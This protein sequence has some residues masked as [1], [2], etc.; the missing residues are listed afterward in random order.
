MCSLCVCSN[1][2]SLACARPIPRTSRLATLLASYAER[3]ARAYPLTKAKIKH[4]EAG[5]SSSEGPCPDSKRDSSSRAVVPPTPS[6]AAYPGCCCPGSVREERMQATKGIGARAER[7]AL[8]HL[9]RFRADGMLLRCLLRVPSIMKLWVFQCPCA[10]GLVA[11][12]GVCIA[13]IARG[14]RAERGIGREGERGG[15]CRSREGEKEREREYVQVSSYEISGP[16][17]ISP[18]VLR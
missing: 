5:S 12:L 15:G 16:R 2:E 8:P 7:G 17:E 4:P 3:E 14:M 18:A 10:L 6:A 1:C 13:L 9:A 11:W